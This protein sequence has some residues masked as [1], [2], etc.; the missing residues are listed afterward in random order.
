MPSSDASIAINRFGLGARADESPPAD[1]HGWLTEQFAR[2]Q[3]APPEIAAQ[4]G[5]HQVAGAISGYLQQIRQLRQQQRLGGGAAA[6]MA[7]AA[8]A[9]PGGAA[10][11]G[12]NAMVPVRPRPA[13]DPNS[14]LAATAA[15]VRQQQH[16]SYANA[17]GA[18]ATVALTTPTPFVERMV[19]FWSNHFAVSGRASSSSS[20]L[21][22][23]VRVR[24]DPPARARQLWRHAGRGRAA[25]DDAALSRSGAIGRADEP[26]RDVGGGPR[27]GAARS[28]STRIW[29]ARSWSCIRWACGTGYDAGRRHRVR[30]RADRLDGKGA[31]QRRSS[32]G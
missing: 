21:M 9:M 3:P 10:P 16:D 7:P 19:H 8:S 18:R 28:G 6:A 26:D 1:P 22:R 12:A 2:Y 24:G 31:E 25:P 32:R 15:F 30:P 5:R 29:R 4:P 20:G 17:V 27:R 11:A 13:A 14:P 23:H